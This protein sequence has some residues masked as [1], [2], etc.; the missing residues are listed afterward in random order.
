MLTVGEVESYINT[1]APFET[2]ESYD[3]TGLLLGN[4]SAG[5]RNVLVTLDV[6]LQAVEEAVSKDANL[7]VSHHPL[8]F[9]ARRTMITGECDAEAMVL[10]KLIRN[11]MHVIA[12]HTDLDKTVYSGSACIVR[13][14][15]L[16]NISQ[17]EY[18]F[19][20]DFE[21]PIA[22]AELEK[23]LERMLDVKVRTYAPQPDGT[24]SRIAVVCGA[25]DEMYPQ[26]RALGAQ[27]LITGEVRH[28]NAIA[29]CM[30]GFVLLDA[31]H[32]ATERILVP[33]LALAL[34]KAFP[35][36]QYNVTFIPSGSDLFVR[37][38]K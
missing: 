33:E 29:A 26:A 7:I 14:L 21:T 30:E 6:T 1:I 27:A 31:G 12:A 18:I 15:G 17:D 11:D 9:H 2:S 20:G 34:Q 4:R 24:V 13:G 16:G 23:K 22:L 32:Y 28:H 3:N 36:V 19:T 35:K 38:T 8:L 37:K 5:V 25:G 10:T